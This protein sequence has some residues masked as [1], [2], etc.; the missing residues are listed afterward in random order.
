MHQSRFSSLQLEPPPPTDNA[1][2]RT[3]P[4]TFTDPDGA[5]SAGLLR[6][7][8]VGRGRGALGSNPRPNQ[9]DP[10]SNPTQPTTQPNSTS[11]S[12]PTFNHHLIQ[13]TQGNYA[14][15]IDDEWV[16]D[17]ADLVA[18]TT[19]FHPVRSRNP[20]LTHL[21]RTLTSSHTQNHSSRRDSLLL[22][23]PPSLTPLRPY[24]QNQVHMNHSRARANVVRYYN[25]GAGQIAYFTTR[26]IGGW[27][28]VGLV[29]LDGSC[30]GL[31]GR[32][33]AT[34]HVQ[35]NQRTSKT[36]QPLHQPQEPGEQLLY[37]YGTA[38]WRGREHLELP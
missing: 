17:A 25:R 2:P 8:Q 9:T 19:N 36:N 5:V 35:T 12:N 38:Y 32:S 16:M 34:Q 11:A 6:L 7:T 29:C 37:D 3:P 31:T 26:D 1:A 24:V 28:P 13:P 20:A 27:G 10:T 22:I 30:L 15:G 14:T 23:C 4:F 21:T 18:D 33:P